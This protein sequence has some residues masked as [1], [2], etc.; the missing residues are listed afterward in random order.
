MSEPWGVS[1][2]VV[3]YNNERFLAAA[4][5]SALGQ[6]HPVSEVIVVDD[7]S[8]DNSRAII[9]RYCDRVRSVLRKSNGHQ[10]A[11]L[12]SAWPLARYPILMFL[13]SDD[14]LLP[15][16]AATVAGLWTAATVKMQFPL[17][18]IDEAGRELG[19]VRPKYQPNL[20]TATIRAEL[21]RTGGSPNS[22]SSGNA[23]SRSLLDRI[24]AD[25]G[26]EMEN[27]REHWMD[28]VLECNAPFYGEVV[29]LHEALTC[30]R[31]HDSNLYGM[32]SIEN[33]R[34][35]M[36][37]R[38]SERKIDYM[39]RRCHY[40]GIPFDPVAA[41]KRSVWHQECQLL[42]AK[43][44]QDPVDDAP[45][46]ITLCCAIR[47]YIGTPMPFAYRILRILW[48]VGVAAA[49][50]RI[51]NRLIAFRFLPGQRPAW[52]EPLLVISGRGSARTHATG[53]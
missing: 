44:N 50:R 24:R 21:L 11:A 17:V 1:I 45:I 25:G 49:P 52:F 31:I 32:N 47:A 34:F 40:W 41:R 51:A 12:N 14:L 23:Y 36:K 8:T 27:S 16:A 39:A 46:S 6:N 37:W 38:T 18:T 35:A 43:A 2:I 26:F 5:D 20:H 30:Y 3:N 22:P 10:I 9:E 53:P 33:A 7:C 48:L 13:D 28:A 42:A 15:H 29:T 4:I 19:H